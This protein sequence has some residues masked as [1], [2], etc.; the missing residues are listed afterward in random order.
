[1]TLVW[2]PVGFLG[3]MVVVLL[4]AMNVSGGSDP[5]PMRTCPVCGHELAMDERVYADQVE[6]ADRPH[7]LTIKG[8]SQCYDRDE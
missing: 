8:C 1:V 2:I 5:R 7:E 6:H 3:V 4:W